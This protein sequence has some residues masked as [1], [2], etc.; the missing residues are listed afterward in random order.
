[1]SI[2]FVS[3]RFVNV[4]MR[5]TYAGPGTHC[6][7]YR[8]LLPHEYCTSSL[9]SNNIYCLNISGLQCTLSSYLL[10]IGGEDRVL[11]SRYK[12]TPVK[13][14]NIILYYAAAAA[15]KDQSS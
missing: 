4:S 1:V 14:K 2:R 6:I 5:Y 7:L 15:V 10:Y 9:P 8:C 3:I 13:G 12:I 11:S